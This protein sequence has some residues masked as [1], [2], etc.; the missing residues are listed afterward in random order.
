M[1]LDHFRTVIDREEPSDALHKLRLFTR[2]YSYGLPGGVHLR[3]Q[4]QALPNCESFLEAVEDHQPPASS[5]R[6]TVE[7]A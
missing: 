1:I 4:I 3:R 2:W 7:A 6:R 5:D